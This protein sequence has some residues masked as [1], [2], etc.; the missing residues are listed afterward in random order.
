[1]D[2]DVSK[3]SLLTTDLTRAGD[4][5]ALSDP[6]GPALSSLTAIMRNTHAK[7]I[8]SQEYGNY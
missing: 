8:S 7:Y 3:L 4:V 1:M 5:Y 6:S 2:S